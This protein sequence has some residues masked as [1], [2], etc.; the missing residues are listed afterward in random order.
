LLVGGGGTNEENKDSDEPRL[1]PLVVG[2][3]GVSQLNT[4]ED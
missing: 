2:Q 4:I 3:E 1:K